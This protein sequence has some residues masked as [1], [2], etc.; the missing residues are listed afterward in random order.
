MVYMHNPHR[1]RFRIRFFVAAVTVVIGVVVVAT[2]DCL[3]SLSQPRHEKS[4][5]ANNP[6]SCCRK[7]DNDDSSRTASHAY[8]PRNGRSQSP[9]EKF[10]EIFAPAPQLVPQPKLVGTR[11]D[12]ALDMLTLRREPKANYAREPK[13]YP[14]HEHGYSDYF[15]DYHDSDP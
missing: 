14:N 15:I 13:R 5:R 12:Q 8:E 1:C 11:R 7:H 6:A 9:A 4:H 3:P 10:E 2:L